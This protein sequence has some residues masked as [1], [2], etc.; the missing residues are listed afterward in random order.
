VVELVRGSHPLHIISDSE[1]MS[2]YHITSKNDQQG[3]SNASS[4]AFS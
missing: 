3:L 2:I 1:A 4:P